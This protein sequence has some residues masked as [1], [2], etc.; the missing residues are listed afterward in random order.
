MLSTRALRHVTARRAISMRQVLCCSLSSALQVH[1]AH[2][3]PGI[4]GQHP[5]PSIS[6]HTIHWVLQ[7]LNSMSHRLPTQ[8]QPQRQRAIAPPLRLG[9]ICQPPMMLV[10]LALRLMLRPRLLLALVAAEP[11]PVAASALLQPGWPARHRLPC[12]RLRQLVFGFPAV[13]ALPGVVP[14][15][16]GGL[17]NCDATWHLHRPG[18][19]ELEET[20]GLEVR[21]GGW[22]GSALPLLVTRQRRSLGF[23]GTRSEQHR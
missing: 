7:H 21:P 3:L 18:R 4:R 2:N 20:A 5:R 23:D 12:C 6:P 8:E 9:Q 11:G 13:G 14:A 10:Q 22:A 17:K 15:C 1:V 19:R 16:D